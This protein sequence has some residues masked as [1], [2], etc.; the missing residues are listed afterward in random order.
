MVVAQLVE[1]LPQ[2]S[3]ICCS[4]PEIGKILFANCKIEE[5]KYTKK[6][7]GMAHLKKTISS[8]IKIGLSGGVGGLAQRKRSRFSPNSQRSHGLS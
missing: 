1:W 3:E 5:T 6:R 4:N 2:T 8:I 7:P